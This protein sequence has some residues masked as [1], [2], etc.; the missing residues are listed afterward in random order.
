MNTVA[1][2]TKNR[3]VR[4]QQE[5]VE[6]LRATGSIEGAEQFWRRMDF[7]KPFGKKLACYGFAKRTRQLLIAK[8]AFPDLNFIEVDAALKAGN[9]LWQLYQLAS[10]C[11]SIARDSNDRYKPSNKSLK[12]VLIAVSRH[13]SPHSRVLPRSKSQT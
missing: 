10:G 6:K 7:N 5:L 4:L 13:G 3:A 11:A 9:K 1:S 8:V 2:V 12:I